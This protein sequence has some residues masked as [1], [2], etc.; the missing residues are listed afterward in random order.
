MVRDDGERE[1]GVVGVPPTVSGRGILDGPVLGGEGKS[2][3][4]MEPD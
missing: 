1:G 3:I 2:T 4:F